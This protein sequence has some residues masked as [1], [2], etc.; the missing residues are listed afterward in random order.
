LGAAVLKAKGLKVRIYVGSAWVLLVG[1]LIG[2][3]LSQLTFASD[4]PPVILG[5]SWLAIIVASLGTLVSADVRAEQ[6]HDQEGS[7]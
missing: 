4:E 6:E 5:L 2:W 7:D 3:P 1:G